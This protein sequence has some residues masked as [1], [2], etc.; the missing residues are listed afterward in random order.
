MQKL[1]SSGEKNFL[2]DLLQKPFGKKSFFGAVIVYF[3]GD[4]KVQTLFLGLLM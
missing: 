4:V 1:K 2:K 3:G